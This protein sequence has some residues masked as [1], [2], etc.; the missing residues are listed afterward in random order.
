MAD[1]VYIVK[2]YENYRSKDN[3]EPYKRA[4][5]SED[6]VKNFLHLK[7]KEENKGKMFDVAEKEIDENLSFREDKHYGDYHW[8]TETISLIKFD[9]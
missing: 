8:E 2:Q 5:L 4:F 3:Y 7:N 1:L 9:Y 6:E